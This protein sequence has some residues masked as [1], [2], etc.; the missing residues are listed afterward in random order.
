[1]MKVGFFGYETNYQ[2]GINYLKNL[3]HAITQLEDKKIDLIVFVGKK[4]DYQQKVY[5]Q[6]ANVIKTSL[7][8]RYSILWFLNRIFVKIFDFPI[9]VDLYC[10]IYKIDVLSHCVFSSKKLFSKSIYWIPDFQILEFPQY[11]KEK[12]VVKWKTIYKKHIENSDMI[13]LSSN[14]ALKNFISFAPNYKSKARV[15]HFVS[16]PSLISNKTNQYE[17][18]K[19]YNISR[20]FFYLPNQFWKHKNHKVVFD[21]VKILKDKDIDVLVICTGLLKDF[22]NNDNSHVNNLLAFIKKNKLEENIKVLGLIEYEEVLCF[23]NSAIAVIN[24][25]LFEGWSSTVEEAKSMGQRIILSNIEVHKEQNPKNGL[26]FK[27]SDANEL[28]KI[29]YQTLKDKHYRPLDKKI[30]EYDLKSRTQEFGMTYQQ[31]IQELSLK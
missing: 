17:V 27:K 2:G 15:M 25:S 22:R 5:G 18:L 12:E 26:F 28:A 31:L 19:K 11:W 14:H 29:L 9:I 24:P 23:M 21:A 13:I 20:P 1:M 30:C 6:Y 7:L 8:D 16:Q 10:R 3:F 4:D